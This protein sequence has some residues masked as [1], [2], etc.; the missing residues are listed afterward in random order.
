MT[1]HSRIGLIVIA[2]VFGTAFAQSALAAPKPL[3]QN[4][5]QLAVNS[6]HR[7][8]ALDLGCQ[9]F[10]WHA[11]YNGHYEWCRSTSGVSA[12]SE[13]IARK[14]TLFSGQC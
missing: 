8:Q 10:R 9:G 11:W 3:C 2:A 1:K 7:M 6:Y 12:Q 5:A 4:Y 13:T 14:R